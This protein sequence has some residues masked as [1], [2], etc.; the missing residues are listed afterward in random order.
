M[1]NSEKNRQPK[2][3]SMPASKK[4][5]GKSLSAAAGIRGGALPPYGVPIREALARGDARE[6]KALATATRQYLK[7]VQSALDKLERAIS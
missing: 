5:S 3:K 4:G 7:N 6:M 2:K 1:P